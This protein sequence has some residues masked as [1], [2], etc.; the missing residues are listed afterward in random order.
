MLFR[1]A[2]VFVH[3]ECDHVGEGDIIV[4]VCLDEM[5]VNEFRTAASR[6]AE[7]EWS[8]RRWFEII[9]SFFEW[10]AGSC[11]LSTSLLTDYVLRYMLRSAI[12]VISNDQLH[13]FRLA[14]QR[15]VIFARG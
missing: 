7:Y 1:Q 12:G 9:D 3:I 8:L 4:L 10:L 11:G 6:Q 13:D 14:I 15:V 5:L 2:D